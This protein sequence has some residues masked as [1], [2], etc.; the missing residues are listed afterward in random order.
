MAVLKALHLKLNHNT[1]WRNSVQRRNMSDPRNPEYRCA[2]SWRA[3]QIYKGRNPIEVR[4]CM[5]DE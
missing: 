2:T 5:H 4:D 3:M 1:S